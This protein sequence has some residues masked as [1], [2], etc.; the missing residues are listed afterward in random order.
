MRK[1]EPPASPANLTI[2]VGSARE[3]RSVRGGDAP[4][5][6]ISERG[7]EN[8][9]GVADTALFDK[10]SQDH[11]GRSRQVTPPDPKSSVPQKP[12]QPRPEEGGAS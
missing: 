2:R 1:R 5:A 7:V 6:R 10:L 11:D 8:S 12:A 3:V 4:I 9:N